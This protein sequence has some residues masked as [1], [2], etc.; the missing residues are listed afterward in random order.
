MQQIN[1][2]ILYP[3]EPQTHATFCRVC[4]HDYTSPK[5]V[6]KIVVAN[7][8]GNDKPEIIFCQKC[9]HTMEANTIFVEMMGIKRI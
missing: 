3:N 8:Y 5:F 7:P 9:S 1:N 2:R 4:G 6:G